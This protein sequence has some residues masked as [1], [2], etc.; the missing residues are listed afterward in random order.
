MA[1]APAGGPCQEVCVA[2]EATHSQTGKSRILTPIA[3]A[4]RARSPGSLVTTGAWCWTAVTMTMAST[5]SAVPEA[6][7][8][9]ADGAAGALVIGED[10]AAFQDPRYLVL[11]PAA[12]RLGQHDH[13]DDQADPGSGR[14]V[15]QGQEVR[16]SAL[17]CEQGASVVDDRAHCRPA[18]RARAPS[19]PMSSLIGSSPGDHLGCLPTSLTPPG[20]VAAGLATAPAS[21]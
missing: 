5:T 17:C 7:A 15:V 2:S 16:V 19:R 4:M 10:V 20:P 18:L 11:R 13:R 1:P 12:P 8:G 21:R 9:D 14:F 6:G 3:S